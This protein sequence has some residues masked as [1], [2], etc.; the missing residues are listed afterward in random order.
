MIAQGEE[1]LRILS[2]NYKLKKAWQV[3]KKN[4]KLKNIVIEIKN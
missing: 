3:R 1:R 2:D 4:L